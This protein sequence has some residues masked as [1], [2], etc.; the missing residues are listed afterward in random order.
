MILSRYADGL[1]LLDIDW[2]Y[3]AGNGADYRQVPNS[4]KTYEIKGFPKLLKAVKKA[5]TPKPLSIAVAGLERD[6]IAFYGNPTPQEIWDTVDFVNIM[7]YDLINRRDTATQHH[8]S[9][10]GSLASVD[11]YLALG[12]PAAK[13]NLG[14]AFYAKYFETKPG[15]N[16]QN[17]PVGCP[18][19]KAE[20]DD[21][22]DAGTSGTV[23]FEKAN[24]ALPQT[25]TNLTISSDGTCG[26]GTSFTCQGLQN[27]TLGC[28]SQY[29]YCGGSQAHCGAGCQRAYGRC[30]GPDVS[31][32]FLK[33]IKNEQID[34]AEG[35]AWYWDADSELFWTWDTPD[36]IARKFHEI[37]AARGLG[38]A[39]AW[40]LAEDSEDW[41]HIRAINEGVQSLH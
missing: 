11:R 41:S 37:I 28:C 18:I 31:A 12:L 38:G 27:A 29:G 14:F 34:Q 19:V 32:S 21:G 20:N 39:M 5:I 7:T 3:P 9:V 6:M 10:R 35:G 33:A 8:T 1:S 2:E 40:S 25:P 23:T 4:K 26:A 36:L 15:E 16:C 22:S 30:E 24:Y 17:R 13:A